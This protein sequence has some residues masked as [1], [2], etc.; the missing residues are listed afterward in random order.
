MK[1][2]GV[3]AHRLFLRHWGSA[4]RYNKARISSFSLIKVIYSSTTA[5]KMSLKLIH[6]TLVTAVLAASA[7]G[8]SVPQSQ[9]DAF[10]VNAYTPSMPEEFDPAAE[11]QRLEA[12]FPSIASGNT[13]E[14][15]AVKQA[16][17]VKVKPDDSGLS[18]FV[19]TVIGTI[20]CQKSGIASATP[21]PQQTQL[22]TPRFQ[23]AISISIM[24]SGNRSFGA[25]ISGDREFNHEFTPEQ[26][27]IIM[28][29]LRAGISQ[30]K[31]T[32]HFNTTQSTISKTKQRWEQ[33]H[34]LGSKPR[35]GRPKKLTPL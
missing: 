28:T 17:S 32:K 23:H 15:R 4:L 13:K 31:V 33:H 26:R 22:T 19:P 7:N 3:I 18:F 27:A 10:S 25:E 6:L 11:I 9:G 8:L 1:I 14:A 21:L 2:P 16:G 24:T 20:T 5:F 29:E 30:R 35:K 12:K 34:N